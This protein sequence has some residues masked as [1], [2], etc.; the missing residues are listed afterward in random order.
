MYNALHPPKQMRRNIQK[1]RPLLRK[2]IENSSSHRSDTE[3]S[4]SSAFVS[5]SVSI[6]GSASLIDIAS[7]SPNQLHENQNSTANADIKTKIET[8]FSEVGVNEKDELSTTQA[9]AL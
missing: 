7:N 4:S 8:E 1:G 3:F 9:A 2:K 5:V 6:S